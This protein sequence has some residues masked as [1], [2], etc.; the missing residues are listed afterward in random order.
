MKSSRVI[1]VLG[2]VFFGLL[3][4]KIQAQSPGGINSGIEYWYKSDAGV[5]SD[6]GVTG[7]TN[8]GAVQQWNDQSGNNYH[9]TQTTLANKPTYY[10]STASQLVNFNPAL[11]F[12]SDW[13]K[14]TTAIMANTSNYT[15]INVVIDEGS[16]NG[17]YRIVTDLAAN[18][19][20][21]F[22]IYKYYADGTNTYKSGWTNY[23]ALS[24]G[25][26]FFNANGNS[27]SNTSGTNAYYN[28]TN[29]T[30][31][32]SAT[33]ILRP[34]VIGIS[35]PASTALSTYI[36]GVK[37]TQT[38]ASSNSTNF[39]NAVSIGAEASGA[40]PWLGRI[41][42]LCAY[43]RQLSDAEIQKVSTYLAIKYGI[44][45]G[46]GGSL[47]NL[48]KDAAGYNYVSSNSTVIWD[49]T[50]NV[51]Y[52]Y[53]IGAIGK[54]NTSGLSQKQSQSSNTGTQVVIGIGNTLSNTNLTNLN[55][56]GSD[57]NFEVWGDNGLSSLFSTPISG[58]SDLN[59]I[60][61]RLWKVQET[62]AVGNVCVAWPGNY[63]NLKLIVSND[64]TI[65]SSD[66]IV[67]TSTVSINGTVYNYAA[68]NFTTGQYFT[69]GEYKQAP[70]GVFTGLEFWYRPESNISLSGSSVASWT[71]VNN[72]RAI[73]PNGTGPSYYSTGTNLINF[74]A[75]LGFSGATHND[76]LRTAT[77]LSALTNSVS[78]FTIMKPLDASNRWFFHW[79]VSG[80][81]Y[82]LN[83]GTCSGNNPGAWT[84]SHGG[85]VNS[86]TALGPMTQASC[87][88]SRWSS[89]AGINT[90]EMRRN[91]L[92]HSGTTTSILLNVPASTALEIGDVNNR[93][94]GNDYN[95]NISEVI[96]YTSRV[97]DA[98]R[99]QIESYLSIK[100][101]ITL[102]NNAGTATNN[103]FSSASTYTV[104]NTTTNAGY[105]NNVAGIARDNIS[106]LM[107]K[108]S[109]SINTG[110]QVIIGLGSAL[111]NSN[112][113]NTNV[114][115][116]D[117]SFE[118]WGDNGGT[119]TYSTS[120]SGSTDVNYRMNRVWKVQETGT[121]GN[122]TI[123]WP[124][125]ATN[126]SLVTNNS[127]PTF[128]SG[129]VFT[130]LNTI[131]INGRYYHAATVDLANNSYFTFAAHGSAPGGVIAGLA[132]WS[133]ADCNQD[134]GPWPDNS[135]YYNDIEVAGAMSIST[136]NLAHN[137]NPYYSN[138]SA[139]NYF[140]E[141]SCSFAP[142]GVY[143]QQSLSAFSAVTPST[144]ST[145]GRI[146]GTD[147]DLLYSAE[148]YLALTAAGNPRYYKYWGGTNA[149]NNTGSVVA[150]QSALAHFVANNTSKQVDVGLNGALTTATWAGN[151]F[152]TWGSY[153]QIGYGNWDLAGAFP[154]DIMEIIWYNRALTAT[155]QLRVNSY[156][157]IKNGVT[158][159]QATATNYLASD[160]STVVWNATANAGYKN[161]IA[162]IARDDKSG[163]LQKQSNCINKG[164]QVIVGLGNALSETNLLNVGAFNSDFCFESWGD[165]GA[166][167]SYSIPISGGTDVNY[168]MTRVW[169]VQE[170]GTVGNVTIA[171]PLN[172][173]NIA[174]VT[175][176]SDPTF[177]SGNVFTPL[178]TIVIN[179]RYYHAATVDL[180]NN[181]YFTFAAYGTAPG[182]V[183]AGLAFWSK[184]DCNL[185]DG[186]WPDNSPN[187]NDIE[188]AGTMNISEANSAHNFHLYYSNFSSTN[189][190]LET[191]CSFAPTGVYTQ[192]SLSAF[193]AITP[194]SVSVGGRITG[195]DNDLTYSAEPHLSLTAAGRPR[196]YK[197]SGTTNALNHANA[198]VA[199]QNSLAHFVANNTS[200]Q[201]DVGLNGALTTANWAGNTYGT[202]GSN[203]LI[204]YGNWDLT[205][206]FPGDI[207]EVIWYNRTLSAI[208]QLRV[209][210]YLAI[211]YGV[212]L[213]QAS[214]TNYVASDGS[215]VVWDATANAGYNNAII[216]IAK[217]DYGSLIQRQ[218][219]STTGDV[220]TMYLGNTK[221][222]YTNLNPS[223]FTTGNM[224][225]FMIGNDGQAVVNS[226]HPHP[227]MPPGIV[228]R[229]KR[230]WKVQKTNFTNTNLTLEFDL[231]AEAVGPIDI[232]DLRLM[233]DNDGTFATGATLYG[234]A[235]S[236]AVTITAEGSIVT[237]SG[238]DASWF[239]S[240]RYFTLGSASE[241]TPL[242]IEL[243]YFNAVPENNEYVKLNWAT[244]SELNC[245]HF[246]VQ[247][248][249][250]AYA[251]EDIGQIK[252][253]GTSNT[254][255]LYETYDFNPN[256]GINYYR[257][258]QFDFDGTYTYST[259]ES[260]N[261]D[262]TENIK[263][264]PNPFRQ[265]C[266]IAFSRDERISELNVYDSQGKLVKTL[267]SPNM[268]SN[269]VELDLSDLALGIYYLKING[270]MQSLKLVKSR[271]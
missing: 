83:Y 251:W 162:A 93:T 129:N 44:T 59:Y 17:T 122:V 161:N 163:L 178:S 151:T 237:I 107:Q 216:G 227:D 206:A 31:N 135:P 126:I 28:G 128:A 156:L 224:S 25:N 193:S 40:E 213:N 77:G 270:T 233:L 208:E 189:Y 159:N 24:S 140:L 23:R 5:F 97:S 81:G 209:N 141:S 168:R 14:N 67:S 199:N 101:G 96:G 37:G 74:N 12:N 223:T 263:V 119:L 147:N 58:I 157:A 255:S 217:D 143:T 11:S 65:N 47:A 149:L 173:T 52:S 33:Q 177:A 179:G 242:P 86:P 56:F 35:S 103:Y 260:V 48:N 230:R 53:N 131:V 71:D 188:V 109:N 254:V 20:D 225:F 222:N 218:S 262:M 236:P 89:T 116:A 7:S 78:S 241:N 174:L 196:F 191:S 106:G 121:V 9:V 41:P 100:Y 19:A 187:D 267:I 219:H 18:N 245:S 120:I 62:G 134:D 172:A 98:E 130:P 26:N 234:N 88:S 15:F 194:T 127:D 49:A 192:Q 1:L 249:P 238:I 154:G 6:A 138:F 13:L 112:A 184:A 68:V 27:F 214:P 244:A 69:F 211:K 90:W 145:G 158:L 39:F 190:F 55:A 34:Q 50:A 136:G 171:W 150:S 180:A 170:T 42:E 202:W 153:L 80:Q 137:F 165:N 220:L 166:S 271:N 182:G 10:N 268:A 72:Y 102:L 63:N 76:G 146:T 75:S 201:I 66:N 29:Y 16:S 175:N 99:Q 252:G 108:Q 231:S 123:A 46:T 51:A 79:G 265:S 43:N 117:M 32:N 94:A 176:S 181:S 139:T 110:A 248:S 239:N 261:F 84:N 195:T 253:A 155:E 210:T 113:L 30:F 212:T 82:Y 148:P 257:L 111:Y 185:G 114:F 215:T 133:K 125:N 22:G 73:V 204:G 226:V 60:M 221:Y 247:R 57:Q 240:A 61:P 8:G 92:L 266:T 4:L 87:I 91:G 269:C 167:V 124:L 70:G 38:L 54:D 256:R 197:Y 169:K 2:M 36:D 118:M 183:I 105:N 64:A 142:A 207:M 235:T 243:L 85:C 246:D 205:G 160:G 45:L 229:L 164:A 3:T 258:K 259:I 115:A 228:S 152:G 21:Y 132:F 186:P 198:V 104:W 95:G 203:M 232:T 200:K 264:Y 250:D 144:A